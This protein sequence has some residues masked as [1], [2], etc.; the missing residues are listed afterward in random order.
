M[1]GP[2]RDL[3]ECRLEVSLVALLRRPD[4]RQHG[5][6]VHRS[7]EHDHRAMR[8]GL[9]R[10]HTGSTREIIRQWALQYVRSHGE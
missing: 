8:G 7:A 6:H 3:P 4:D 10:E 1:K 9:L 2:H 5:I